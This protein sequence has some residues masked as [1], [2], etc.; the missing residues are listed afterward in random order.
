MDLVGLYPWIV[1]LHIAGAFV[2][3]LAHG[4]SAFVSDQ[5]RKE[6][7]VDRIR[8]LLDVSRSSIAMA[9]GGLITLLVSG[10]VAGIVGNHF[11]RG[12]IWVS[13][14]LLIAIMVAMYALAARYYAQVRTAVGLP[15]Y[16]DKK[17]VAPPPPASPEELDRL[18]RT[19]RPDVIGGIGFFGLLLILA[20][21]VFKPF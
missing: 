7:N 5:I 1:F 13:L 17:G 2:F 16:T 20:L 6:R 3:V 4:V 18:L 14:G 15:S 12:W 9:Y 21:M 10:I 11:S 19:S 8:A